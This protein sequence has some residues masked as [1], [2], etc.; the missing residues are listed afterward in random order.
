MNYKFKTKPYAHQLKALEMSWE[1]PYFAYFMEMG[2]GKSKVLIDNMSMLYDNGKINGALIIAPKGVYKN[3]FS[4]EIPTHMAAHIEPVTVLWKSLINKKQQFYL[5]Q[6][7]KTG[8]DFH[9]LV[10]NVESLSTTKGVAFAEKFLNC[11]NAMMAIDEST[12]IKNPD[13]KRT[14][15][16]VGLGK[17]AKYRRILTGSPVTKSP[18]DLY[19]Q[20]EFLQDELLGFS[21][22]YAFRTRYAVMKTANFSG[23]SVQIVVGYR[24]LD[25]L[26]E[27]LKAFSYRVLKDECLDLPKKTFMKREVLLTKEQEKAYLQMKQLAVAHMEGKVMTTATVLTQLM[28]L[29]QI[30]CGHFTADDGTLHEVPSNRINELLDVL[31]E[32]EGKVVIWAQFQRDVTNIIKALSKEYGDDSYVDYYGLTPQEDRQRNIKKFQDPDSPVRF[33]IGTTQ[34][35]GYGITLTAASTMVYYSNGYDLEKRQQSEARIDRI[36][37]EKPMTYID[38]ICEDTVDTRIVKALRKKVDIATQIMGEELK[39]WI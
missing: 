2:T 26:S 22:Y 32:V 19:K 30:T 20:C 9:I 18:L 17:L 11:H 35:G 24:N 12:T 34:T 29:Q 16:I 14:K 6:L 23:R 4:Q 27:K 1:R 31:S 38:I 15:N 21:S 8:E 39:S 33:F 3:W 25:E 5:D 13:A 10:M 36:G 37:Q 7:F 28:R